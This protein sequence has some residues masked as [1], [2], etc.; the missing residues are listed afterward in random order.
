VFL[1]YT[2]ILHQ[3]QKYVNI[4]TC[5]GNPR[6]LAK[7][8]TRGLPKKTMGVIMGIQKKG[9]IK[10]RQWM[11]GLALPTLALLMLCGGCASRNSVEDGVPFGAHLYPADYY[12]G[13]KKDELTL[14][15]FRTPDKR[16]QN[17]AKLLETMEEVMRKGRHK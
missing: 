9:G 17:V 10:I 6:T 16:V 1:I 4:L 15:Y 3:K 13:T 5:D 2:I 12:V 14:A 7:S 8:T 11:W